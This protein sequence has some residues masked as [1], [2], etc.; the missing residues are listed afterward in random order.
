MSGLAAAG[1]LTGCAVNPATGERQ[2]ML[3][4]EEYEIDVDRQNSPHQLSSDYGVIQDRKL[5]NYIQGVGK[6][7]VAVTHRPQM[8]YTFQGVNATYINAYAFP[9]GTIAATRG[10]LLSLDNEAELSALMGHELGHVNARHTARQMSKG[11]ITQLVV[12]GLAGYAATKGEVWGGLAAQVGMLGAGALL[13]SYSRDNEREADRLGM[14]YMVKSGYGT[15]GF[16]GLMDMLKGLSHQKPNAVQLLFATHPMSDERYQ[17]AVDRAAAEYPN[18]KNNPVY[19]ERYMDNTA[20]L[21]SIKGAILAMQAGES[22]MA[23]KKYDVAEKEFKSALRQAPNDYAG[24]LMMSKCLIAQ[25]KNSEAL[26]Y[27]QKA[28]RIYPAEAQ[29]HQLSG[30]N[31][32]QIRQY[33]AA[34]RDFNRCDNLLPG[35]PTLSYFMGLTQ[36]KMQ[37]RKAAAKHYYQYLKSV[38]QGDR[39]QYAY[40]RMV[41]WGYIKKQTTSKK[42]SQ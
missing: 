11:I 33:S 26:R 41:N 29:A 18:Y 5:N 34:Y 2:L 16:V 14:G 37:H 17:T 39:A 24:L 4:S 42:R 28:Q 25:N 6:K 32:L 10:I 21:R 31:K 9:G 23:K 1:V 36:E 30:Y 3:V 22:A 12:A 27:S 19:R 38:Q 40:N 7:M 35:N 13:A 15:P 8:P 20:G